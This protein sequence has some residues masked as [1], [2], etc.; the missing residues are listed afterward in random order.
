MSIT[1]THSTLTTLT[2]PTG[3]LACECCRDQVEQQLRQHPHVQSVH[4]DWGHQ[5]AHVQ[6]DAGG[7]TAEEL[8]ELV[9]CACG[10]RNPVP[11]PQ[12]EVSSHAHAHS[13]SA[14]PMDHAAMGHTAPAEHAGMGH[15]HHDMSDPR[16]AAAMEAD[17]KRRFFISLVLAIPTILYSP[18]ATMIFRL[19]LPTPFGIPHDWVMLIFSTPIALW[20]S[21]V[22]HSGAY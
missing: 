17:M 3:Q 20:T 11:L 1:H 12:P 18:M 14:A 4:F 13:A 7:P 2:V 22:F 6:V 16:M 5:V 8:A 10:E 19:Y 15:G 21:S 9:A